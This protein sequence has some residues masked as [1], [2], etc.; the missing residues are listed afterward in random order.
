MVED[1]PRDDIIFRT[2]HGSRVDYVVSGDRHPLTQGEFRG[3]EI[4]G[5]GPG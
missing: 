3:I 4:L 1:D 5:S 2:A